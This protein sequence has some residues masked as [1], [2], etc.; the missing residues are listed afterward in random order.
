MGNHRA[1]RRGPAAAPRRPRTQAPPRSASARRTRRDA[2]SR[3]PLLRGLPSAPILAR[4][5]RPRRL[6]RRRRHRRRPR[7]RRPPARRASRRPA[8]S[9]APATSPAGAC[10]TPAPPRVSRDSRRDAL[11][12]AAD[13]ELVDRGRGAGPAAQRRPGPVRQ[14]GRDAGRQDRAQPVGAPGRRLPPH[15]HAS[16]SPA[17]CGRRSHTGLDFAAPERHPDPRDRQRRRHL[18]RLRRLLRQQDRGHPRRRHRAVVL[19][20]ERRSRQRRRQPVRAGEVIGYV[21][22]TG[23]VTG[24]HLHLEVRPGGGD[25]VD[26]YEALSSTGCSRSVPR[27][28][29]R[30]GAACTCAASAAA[31]ARPRRRR[32]RSIAAATASRPARS[33]AAAA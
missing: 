8:P 6:R 12:D 33:A 20:P 9:A 15:R 22:S 21:G 14:A 24:P 27:A 28:P 18:D 3:G 16:A 4:R 31:P 1:D 19:P 13:A 25:P 2:R 23:N 5:R 17:A 11:A 26:P 29:A 30:L 7:A 32:Q 10:S